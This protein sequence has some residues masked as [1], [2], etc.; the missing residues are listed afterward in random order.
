[1]E[2]I[3]R[4]RQPQPPPAGMALTAYTERMAADAAAAASMEASAGGGEFFSTQGGQLRFAG[5]PMPGNQIAAVVLDSILEN[6]FY[7]GRFDPDNPSS[8]VC[9]AYGTD[10]REMGPHTNVIAAHN[11][12]HE[13]CIGCPQNEWGSADTGR[14]KACR[15][16]R[17]LA[18][19]PAGTFNNAGAGPVYEPLADPAEIARAGV[20]FLKL[21]VTSVKAYANW[22]RGLAATLKRPPYAVVA[23]IRVLPDPQTQFRIEVT[24][25]I[26]VPD[27]WLPG[28]M[29]KRDECQPALWAPHPEFRAPAAPASRRAREAAPSVPAGRAG[30]RF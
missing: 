5:A 24:A 27:D 1:M 14:G 21:P 9:Y 17:R 8:P 29:A 7:E 10:E 16:T 25:L 18:L 13:T 22:V 3:R 28:I 30:A 26:P 6:V 15:N 11:H 12:Q 19:I 4:Q 2:P 23:R 20:A